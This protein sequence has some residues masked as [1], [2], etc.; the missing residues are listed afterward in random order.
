MKLRL[1]DQVIDIPKPLTWQDIRRIVILTDDV[2]RL[3]WF[4]G[5]KLTEQ[6]LYEE[7][8]KRYNDELE[9]NNRGSGI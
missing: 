6:E 1:Q 2:A 7:V 3:A 9:N 4:Q 5:K 8:L